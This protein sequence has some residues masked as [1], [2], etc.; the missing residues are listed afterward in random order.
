MNVVVAGGRGFI[1][2]PLVAA[3]RGQ[4][5]V[6]TVL[7][8]TV[9]PGLPA[10]AGVMAWPAAPEHAPSP[11]RQAVAG[12]DAIVNLSGESIA[13]GRWTPAQKQRILQSRV[14]ATR[15]IVEAA[16]AAERPGRVLVNASAVGFYGPR[17]DEPVTEN[18]GPGGDFLSGVC[19]AWEAEARRAA[20]GG[21]RVVLPRFGLVLARDGGA[22][23]RMAM[24]FRLFAGGPL[25]SGRQWVP[26]IHRDDV[27]ALLLLLVADSAARGPVNAVGPEPARNRDFARALGRALGRPS[28]LP[29][30]APLLRLALGEAADGLLL[31]GQRALPQR[32]GALGYRFRHTTV[33]AA[34]R[35][36][37]GS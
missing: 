29:A 11:W 15:A 14:N 10:G 22:L 30:P 1:G 9:G 31:A 24:P 26:W 20:S 32:A 5:D 35:A 16:S 8:R 17:G 7:S 12:A 27:V 28:W 3:L 25:G 13:G 36:V 2:A 34:L 6:V 4:G 33:G 23:P 21:L 37:Y 18:D 19:A